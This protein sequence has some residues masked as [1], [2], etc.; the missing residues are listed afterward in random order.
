MKWS[1][2]T[3]CMYPI[4]EHINWNGTTKSS[5]FQPSISEE[6][7]RDIMALDVDNDKK[8]LLLLGIGVF[9]DENKAIRDTWKS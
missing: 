6:N 4:P 9:I 2:W 1:I 3:T 8:M 5:P 7:V